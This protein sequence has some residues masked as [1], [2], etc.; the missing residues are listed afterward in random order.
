MSSDIPFARAILRDIIKSLR[1][2]QG[3]DVTEKRMAKAIE[4]TILSTE[5]ALA[6][7]TRE[8]FK[9]YRARVKSEPLDAEKAEEIRQ[10]VKKNPGA[11]V[12]D[13][14]IIFNVNQGRI[15]EALQGKV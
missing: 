9:P 1:A 6:N 15:T 3:P 2:H 5:V 14:A 10:F 11:S 8:T 7:M 13:A 4:N 12:K